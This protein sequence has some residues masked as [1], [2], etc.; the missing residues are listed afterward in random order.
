MPCVAECMCAMSCDVRNEQI[1]SNKKIYKMTWHVAAS[2]IEYTE[3]CRRREC[4][5]FLF[6]RSQNVVFVPT[7]I[8]ATSQP[9]I[10][11]RTHI[12]HTSFGTAECVLVFLVK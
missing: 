5:F 9:S 6:S 2:N 8:A 11:V 4:L 12:A 10:H 1:A 7:L 3:A